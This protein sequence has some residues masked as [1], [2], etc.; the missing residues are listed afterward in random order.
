MMQH[1]A[2]I[3]DGNRRWAQARGLPVWMG[4]RQGVKT[5]EMVLEYCLKHEIPYI[6]LYTFSLENL[7]RSEEEKSQLFAVIDELQAR[8]K[9]FIDKGIRIC[10]VGDLQYLPSHTRNTCVLLEQETKK[11]TKLICQVLLCYGGQQ[12]I[13]RAARLCVQDNVTS[14]FEKEFKARL[15]SNES[16]DPNLII[17][18]GNVQRL[19]NFLLFQSAYAEIRFLECMWPDLTEQILDQTVRSAV[20]VA[21][22]FG[23]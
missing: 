8:V 15:W 1:I 2:I 7:R 12:E 17:R 4:H 22:R 14:D 13:L 19:S 5:V 21:K 23:A 18:T 16:P 11:Q 20:T 6:S 3:M 10:F 9:E